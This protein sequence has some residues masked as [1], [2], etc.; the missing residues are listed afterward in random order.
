MMGSKGPWNL[1]RH[2][3]SLTSGQASPLSIVSLPPSI[4]DSEW[5]KKKE[6]GVFA[7]PSPCISTSCQSR[8]CLIGCAWWEGFQMH[9]VTLAAHHKAGPCARAVGESGGVAFTGEG[10]KL[11]PRINYENYQMCLIQMLARR[12]GHSSLKLSSV[13]ESQL[14]QAG[15]AARETLVLSSVRLF[16]FISHIT[17]SS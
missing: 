10:R 9:P 1:P 14:Q 12:K 6:P 3:W 8:S 4:A 2:V 17:F 16:S 15:E 7:L 5:K 13:L 11:Q